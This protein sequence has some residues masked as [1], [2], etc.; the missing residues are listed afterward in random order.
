MG[1]SEISSQRGQFVWD[2]GAGAGQHQG[3]CVDPEQ[4]CQAVPGRQG[5][6]GL[7]LALRRHGAG[8]EEGEGQRK[9]LLTGQVLGRETAKRPPK[10]QGRARGRKEGQKQRDRRWRQ[11]GKRQEE[12][13]AHGRAA[14]APQ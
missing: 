2:P 9:T 3:H 10:T 4:S 7:L 6:P 8:D 12:D 5:V 11:T 1:S 14:G 13:N